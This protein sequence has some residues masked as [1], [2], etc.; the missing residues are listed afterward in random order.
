MRCSCVYDPVRDIQAV[1]QTGAV[2]LAKANAMSSIPASLSAEQLSYNEID[3]PRSIAGR[4]SDVF[5]AAQASK[6]ITAY[7]PPKKDKQE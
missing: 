6:A 2:D 5:E 4:P 3:D 1:S 7:V